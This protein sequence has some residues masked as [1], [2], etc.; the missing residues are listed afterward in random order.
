MSGADVHSTEAR[1]ARALLDPARPVPW[2]VADPAGH[3]DPLR[4][5]IHRNTVSAALTGALEARYPTVLRLVGEAFFRAMARAFAAIDRPRSP[6]LHD[7]GTGFPDFV[8]GFGPADAVPYLA[9]VARVDDAWMRAYVAADADPLA[10]DRLAALDPEA[11]AASSLVPHPATSLV[12]SPHPAGSV[13]I[14]NR[15]DPVGRVDDWRGEGVLVVRPDASVD[16][17]VLPACDVAF[18]AAVLAGRP[19]A[20]AATAATDPAFDFGRALVG[21][22][23]AGAFVAVTPA[24]GDPA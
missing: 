2:D 5:A 18:A 23:S 7:Y 6:L 15:A 17:H 19:L 10:L 22:V 20:E 9:D 12:V 8:A 3:A 11:L 13:W 4:F 14:A 24:P 16:V 1:F 21:L